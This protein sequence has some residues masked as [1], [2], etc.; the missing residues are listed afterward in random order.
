MTTNQKAAELAMGRIFGMMQR[1]EQAGDLAEYQR[2]KQ[3]IMDAV[4][5]ETS[6]TE[7]CFA[8]DY[9]SILMSGQAA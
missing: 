4:G 7:H 8:R 2:C 9:R 5:F 1:P 3:I 6:D